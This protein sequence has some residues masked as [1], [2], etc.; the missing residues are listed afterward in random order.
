M[1]SEMADMTFTKLKCDKKAGTFIR[2]YW[3]VIDEIQN[4]SEQLADYAIQVVW[5]LQ[6]EEWLAII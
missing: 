1:G 6:V 2:N 3:Y 5:L 4:W